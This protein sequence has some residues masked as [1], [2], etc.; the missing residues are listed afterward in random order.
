[1]SAPFNTSLP[2]RRLFELPTIA[3]LA[4][5]L[6][7]LRENP[8]DKPPELP[9][10]LVP[11]RVV[12]GGE[13]LFCF[14]P[15]GGGVSSFTTLIELLPGVSLYGLQSEG[16]ALSETIRH[17]TVETMAAYYVDLIRSVQKSGPYWLIG[18]S[19]GGHIAFETARILTEMGEEVAAVMMLDT[20]APGRL[21]WHASDLN[22][23]TFMADGGLDG[24][25]EELAKLQGDA[26]LAL[27][28]E[29][30]KQRGLVP[31]NYSLELGRRRLAVV[32]NNLHAANSYLPQPHQGNV[33]LF[34][35]EASPAE[36]IEVWKRFVSSALEVRHVVGQHSQLLNQPFVRQI[37]AHIQTFMGEAGNKSLAARMVS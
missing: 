28:I 30:L 5:A 11:I 21:P 20:A 6:L 16:F 9:S 24:D 10:S 33:V 32:K 37:A 19:S 22:L 13:T 15:L 31:K 27:A 23:I 12:D 14:H 1:M 3:Q 2:L 7:A 34:A 25:Q 26:Q 17:T 36:N 4:P 35:A 18:R 8:G 29:K